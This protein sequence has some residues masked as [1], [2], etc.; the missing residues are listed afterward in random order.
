MAGGGS[1]SGGR[2]ADNGIMWIGRPRVPPPSTDRKCS[3]QYQHAPH[4]SSAG[5]AHPSSEVTRPR[6]RQPV[7]PGPPDPRR[8]FPALASG[9]LLA[10]PDRSRRSL[11]I[12]AAFRAQPDGQWSRLLPMPGDRIT[13]YVSVGDSDVAYQVVGDGSFDLVWAY[14]LGTQVDLIWDAPW[15]AKSISVFASATRFI[16]LDRRG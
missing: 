5:L 6:S 8:L 1:S 2:P 10:V 14:N 16:L 15:L 3:G 7:I 9:L 12:T 4:P 13:K 11:D